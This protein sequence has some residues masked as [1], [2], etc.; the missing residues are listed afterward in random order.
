MSA[1]LVRPQINEIIG[2]Y[3]AELQEMI[4]ERHALSGEEEKAVDM[5]DDWEKEMDKQ[6]LNILFKK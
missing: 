4:D 1:D 5:R 3:N 6:A 2:E